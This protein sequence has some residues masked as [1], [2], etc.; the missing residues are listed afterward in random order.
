LN[1]VKYYYINRLFQAE[2]WKKF[3]NG[4]ISWIAINEFLKKLTLIANTK[5]IDFFKRI[6][7][8]G[9]KINR[10]TYQDFMDE[11][12]L[13]FEGNILVFLSQKDFIA[14][15]FIDHLASTSAWPIKE[16]GKYSFFEV[17][18]ADHTFTQASARHFVEEKTIHW[19][20][21]F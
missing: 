4:G 11:A 13:S 7:N 3:F 18:G 8:N 16:A 12:W 15:E 6:A 21:S 2:F 9:N 1:T 14:K 19:M 5:L 17:A 10:K 20:N